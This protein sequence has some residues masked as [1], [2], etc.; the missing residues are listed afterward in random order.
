MDR[1]IDQS[2][3]NK[4]RNGRIL[5]WVIA[6]IAVLAAIYF[7]MRLL[8][9][10][11]DEDN[12]RF[13]T[14]ERGE[15]LNTIT[16]TATVLP[17]FEEQLNAPVS[18]TI[19]EVL[20]TAGREVK[21]GELIMKLDRDYVGLQLDGRRDQL[22]LKENNIGLLNLEY[23]RD[24]KDFGYDAEIKKLEL[25]AAEARL[26]D[27]RRLLKIGG[28][29]AEEVEAAELAVKITKLESDKLDN[30]LAY[31]QNSLAGR[32]RQLQLEVG[33]EEK[34]VQ[35]L[36]RKM[37][38]TEVRAPR[39]GV[40][41]WV[42]ENIGQQVTE[43]APLARIANLGR[44]KIEATCSDR[45][46]E[47]INVGLPIEM[48]INGAKLPGKISSIL[49]EV[50]DNALRFRV[51]LDNPSNDNLR[52]NLRAEL[53]VI[54]NRREDVLRVKNGPAFRGGKMQSVFAIRGEE[55][56]R[57]E[58]ATGIRNGDFVEILGGL[59]AGDRI[60]ISDTE[61]LERVSSFKLT[62]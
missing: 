34:E 24:L 48:R 12:L 30:A 53:Y 25:A 38:E 40:V 37:R 58:V 41:T 50:T 3:I 60:I 29:T 14:V 6:I 17:A 15:V 31:S 23:E 43:G 7:G 13:A 32:K 2:S 27:A 11:A 4:R 46:A 44:Y 55:A 42:N 59:E 22:A 10:T 9:P 33:M 35:Q 52:P 45:F 47:Q 21:A 61:E 28:A 54:T 57:L 62:E 49:P 1:T 16:A 5:T 18:T 19:D 36:S 20:L 51:E 8:R 39:P 26:A 56:V